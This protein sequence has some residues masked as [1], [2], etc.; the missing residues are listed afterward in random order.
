[1][2]PLD[3]VVIV[4]IALWALLGA[5]R[6]L[7][8]QVLS[9]TGLVAGALAGSRIAPAL[10]PD[11]RESVWLP[12]VALAGALVG[13]VLAQALLLR[14]ARP[15]RRWVADGRA[16]TAD[17][18]GGIVL[19]ALGGLALAWL[20]AAV[21]I[22]QPGGRDLA[23]RQDVHESRILGTALRLVPPDD[24]LG[25][26]ARMDAFPIIPLPAATLPEPDPSV[27]RSPGARAARQSV[28]QLRGSACGLTKQGSGWV[29]GDDLVVTNA[30]V[31]AG[32]DDT[33]V[34]VAG[35]PSLEAE[36]VY[37]DGTN[38]VAVLRVEGL[39]LPALALGDAPGGAESVTLL[40]YPDGG[41]LT[42]LAG[43]ASAPRTAI[44]SDA[45]GNG[46]TVRSIIVTRGTLGPGSSGGPIV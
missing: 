33:R 28:V 1:M 17:R 27:S 16:R 12:L 11:G 38:D 22:F 20:M 15:L 2:T 6:G 8:E 45:Y 14:L 46:G 41:P 42:A 43:T 19:G 31:I 24:L 25:A 37:V 21:I 3:Y 36:P 40:G 32:E 29:A 23:L 4:W 5:G 26:L 44:T 7:V 34:T 9:L 39:D 13:A 30:H 18:G 35:G 10:L